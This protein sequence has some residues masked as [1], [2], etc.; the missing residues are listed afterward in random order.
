MREGRVLFFCWKGGGGFLGFD[1]IKG[2]A[3]I[4]FTII[5]DLKQFVSL[6]FTSSFLF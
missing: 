3:L 5:I 6:Y 4:L 1:K 2:G